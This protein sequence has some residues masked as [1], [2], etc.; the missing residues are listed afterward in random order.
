ML[1]CVAPVT[2]QLK[3]VLCPL[4]IVAKEAEKLAMAGACLKA[5]GTAL[6]GKHPVISNAEITSRAEIATIAGALEP[7]GT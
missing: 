4:V 1:T 7:P 5:V 2:V 3:I 6:L